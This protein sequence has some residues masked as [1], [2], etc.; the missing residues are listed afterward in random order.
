MFFDTFHYRMESVYGTLEQL[1]AYRPDLLVSR[2]REYFQKA[3]R[4][5]L[6]GEWDWG[7]SIPAPKEGSHTVEMHELLV[8]NR[9]R[10]VYDDTLNTPPTGGAHRGWRPRWRP[11]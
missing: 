3:R 5:V 7:T 11:C 1:N 4:L 8:H 9:I 10:H 2:H 6:M